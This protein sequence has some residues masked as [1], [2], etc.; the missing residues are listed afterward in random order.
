M[1]P[2]VKEPFSLENLDFTYRVNFRA[3]VQLTQLAIPHLEKSRG[4]IINISSIC[5]TCAYPALSYYGSL[6]AALDHLTRH[7]ALAYGSKGIRVNA[8]N[9]GPV[10]SAV[11]ERHG[12]SQQ[13]V[14]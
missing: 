1:K 11:F 6:K 4:N 8:L 9:P 13:G 2:G 10:R 12:I 5:S 3:V 7:D 14:C